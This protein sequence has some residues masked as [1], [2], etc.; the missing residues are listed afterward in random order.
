MLEHKNGVQR[1]NELHMER[2]FVEWDLFSGSVFEDQ[3][4]INSSY[5]G[6][7]V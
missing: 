5:L 1:V 7:G 4:R 3:D 2:I 6:L